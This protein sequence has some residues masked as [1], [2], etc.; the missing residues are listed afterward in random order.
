M[1]TPRPEKPGLEREVV[2]SEE[3]WQLLWEKR[4]KALRIMRALQDLDPIVHGSIARGDVTPESDVDVVILRPV[5]YSIVRT[6]LEAAGLR[7][8]HV[9]LVMATPRTTPKLYIYLDP[10]EEQVVTIPVIKLSK[11][12]E[13]F[14]KF[15]GMLNLKDLENN[16]RTC[17]VNKR[18]M[19]I[20][21]TDRGH[22]EWCIIGRE[23]EVCSLLGVSIEVVQERV[24]ML[25]RRA[26]VGRTGTFMRILLDP[27]DAVEDVVRRELE[28]RGLRW[29]LRQL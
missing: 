22:I 15:S 19:F 7:I 16:V 11:V 12:E 4:R 2:Y 6:K 25:T 26:E 14:Y 13:E 18:L 21:P 5:P 28:K 29:V 9:E 27:D 1:S 23:H 20:K 24:K 8:S 17:G 10:E 3:H